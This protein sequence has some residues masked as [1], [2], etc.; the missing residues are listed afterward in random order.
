ML[1]VIFFIVFIVSLVILTVIVFRK[2]PLLLE[3]PETASFQF[4]W[5]EWLVKVRDVLPVGNFS[6]EI[7]LQKIFS[8][9]RVLALK[10]DNKTSN[11]LQRLRKRSQKKKFNE[12][13]NYWQEIKNYT[14]K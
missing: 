10:T 8:K 2:I 7:F 11:W 13:D 1:S 3:L 6:F 12:E 14:K 9:I 5:K 4:N